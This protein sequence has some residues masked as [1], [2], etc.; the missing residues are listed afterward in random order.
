MYS[1]DGS[2]STN[3]IDKKAW[4]DSVAAANNALHMNL[5]KDVRHFFVRQDGV[6]IQKPW[7]AN[8]EPY[9]S[10]GSFINVGGGD[11]PKGS[12]TYIDI[13]KGVK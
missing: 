4:Q 2:A 6:G 3:S 9:K 11:A 13:Y 10:Y 7:W 12:K 1:K 5:D 8:G